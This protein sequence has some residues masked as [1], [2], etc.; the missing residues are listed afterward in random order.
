MVSCDVCLCPVVYLQARPGV[1]SKPWS[2][3]TNPLKTAHIGSKTTSATARRFSP[4]ADRLG[5]LMPPINPRPP[6]LLATHP[7]S[8]S[9]LTTCHSLLAELL[10]FTS[11]TFFATATARL[12]PQRSEMSTV[13]RA[14]LDQ[15]L[16]LAKRCSQGTCIGVHTAL[17]G[18]K[19]SC[20]DAL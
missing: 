4:S 14:S 9:S 3:G 1:D 16:A 2:L 8:S 12:Q 13:S 20:L 15:K 19:Q 7:S 5:S 10:H 17:A 11:Q 18:L 6:L